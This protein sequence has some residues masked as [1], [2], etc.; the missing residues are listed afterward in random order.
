MNIN[1]QSMI[2]RALLASTIKVLA[3][4]GSLGERMLK[5]HGVNKIYNDREYPLH[6]RARFFEFNKS[7]GKMNSHLRLSSTFY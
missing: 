3:G 7:L 2:P 4:L 5:E 1:Y 6:L